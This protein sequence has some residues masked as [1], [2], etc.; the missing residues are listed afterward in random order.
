ML[1]AQHRLTAA[2]DF[3]RTIRSGAKTV[4]PTVIIHCANGES[5]GPARF[6]ITVSK[7]VG[8]SVIRHRVA[9]QIRHAIAEVLNSDSGSIPAGSR[10]VFRALPQAAGGGV[11]TDVRIAMARTAEKMK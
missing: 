4:T 1:P 11:A 8:G 5:A 3:R 9:R 2:D 7:A 6:G 10:W